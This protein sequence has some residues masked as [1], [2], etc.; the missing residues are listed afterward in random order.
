MF[1]GEDFYSLNLSVAG[2][3]LGATGLYSQGGSS[4][5]RLFLFNLNHVF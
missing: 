3:R 2:L 1:L 4:G 5:V